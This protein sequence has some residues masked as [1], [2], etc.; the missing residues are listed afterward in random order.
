MSSGRVAELL[1]L[2]YGD[3]Y[4]DIKMACIPHLVSALRNDT[5]EKTTWT[6][7][8][9]I[10]ESHFKGDLEHVTD[11]L[12]LLWKSVSQNNVPAKATGSRDTHSVSVFLVHF[13]VELNS[14]CWDRPSLYL[15][16]VLRVGVPFRRQ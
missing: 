4:D 8:C 11:T 15:P 7:L 9:E 5:A 12:S 2:I 13:R 6:R 16:A 14:E 10:I 1:E 3:R